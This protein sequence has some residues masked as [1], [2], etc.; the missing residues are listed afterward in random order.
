MGTSTG[1]GTYITILDVIIK[2]LDA[3]DTINTDII[4]A[5]D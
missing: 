3:L 4:E 1:T 5:V 2:D